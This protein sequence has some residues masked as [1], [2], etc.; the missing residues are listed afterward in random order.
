MG[1]NFVVGA[2]GVVTLVYALLSHQCRHGVSEVI[3]ESLQ[4]TNQTTNQ[5]SNEQTNQA[6]RSFV[7]IRLVILKS[8]FFSSFTNFCLS[9][10]S[11]RLGIR[12]TISDKNEQ[13]SCKNILVH[14]LLILSKSMLQNVRTQQLV[15]AIKENLVSKVNNE[16]L[17]CSW[18]I[19]LIGDT[20]DY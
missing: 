1:S 2:V 6:Q 14:G 13:N 15:K 20:I 4:S 11:R 16:L 5:P 3:V 9:T 8:I 18:E 17:Q 19:K 12:K 7:R 10:C